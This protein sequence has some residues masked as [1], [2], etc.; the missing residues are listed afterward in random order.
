[1]I[2]DDGTITP[3]NNIICGPCCDGICGWFGCSMPGVCSCQQH[4]DDEEAT[5]EP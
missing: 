2:N 4:E 3:P 5:S 1:M